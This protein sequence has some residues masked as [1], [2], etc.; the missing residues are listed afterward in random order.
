V[1]QTPKLIGSAPVLLVADVGKAANYY[2]DQLGF[3]YDRFWGEPP[4]FCMVKRDGFIV[5]LAQAPAGARLVPHW[6]VVSNM[7]N[8]YFWCDDVEALH[9]EFVKRGAHIDYGLGIKPYGI[10]EFGIQ[11]LDGHDIAFGQ[12]I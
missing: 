8:A 6:R 1:A 5:M 7:W 4:D 10:K 2:R 9:A 11:D 12:R 3:A